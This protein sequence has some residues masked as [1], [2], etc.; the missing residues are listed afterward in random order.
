MITC[1]YPCG[2]LELL[3][4][5]GGELWLF[6]DQLKRLLTKNRPQT[7]ARHR[8]HVKKPGI[9]PRRPINHNRQSQAPVQSQPTNQP[10]SNEQPLQTTTS[11]SAAVLVL[12]LDDANEPLAQPQWL[13]GEIGERLHFRPQQFDDY[14]LY[15]IIGFTTTF[16]NPYQI[17]TLQFTKKLGHPVV[18][19]PTDYDTGELLGPPV[20]QSG[21]L[22]DP[23]AFALP[24]IDGYHMI[25]AN[26]PLTGH[27]T[28]QAQV[29]VV[30]LRRSN[31]SSV[32]RVNLYVQVLYDTL[33]VDL[34]AGDPYDFEFPQNSIWRAFIRINTV[35]DGTWYNL[36]GP[37]WISG[38]NVQLTEKPP[39]HKLALKP[40]SSLRLSTHLGRLTT[41][42]IKNYTRTSRQMVKPDSNSLTV[43]QSRLLVDSR[44]I[45]RLPGT[46]LTIIV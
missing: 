14:L 42:L 10:T 39:S 20:T 2:I 8:K 19:Y 6:F 15:H 16:T 34:P 21:H 5:R 3:I 32:Q 28:N 17:M 27:F 23:F 4:W 18:L 40:R 46:G 1:P 12:Y 7:P 44:M 24:E 45:T 37:Q 29:I 43:R 31:W 25:K 26:R 9:P 11:I 36:G 22:N 41:W 13:H 38:K 35:H 33:I 30:M